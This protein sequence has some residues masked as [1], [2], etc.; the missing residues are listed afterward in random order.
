[1]TKISKQK[2]NDMDKLIAATSYIFIL[3]VIPLILGHRN[4]FIHDHGRQGAALFVF[5]LALMVIAIIPILGWLAAAA[6]WLF[7]MVAAIIGIF[8]ALSG[9]EY[10]IPYLNKIIH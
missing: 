5:E 2:L 4:K 7:V 3:F 10:E 1:M 6:G 8:R 9:E